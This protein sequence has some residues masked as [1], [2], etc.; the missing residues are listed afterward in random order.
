MSA[1]H[2]G[3][4]RSTPTGLTVSIH[5]LLYETPF[6]PNGVCRTNLHMRSLIIPYDNVR[7]KMLSL[8]V[9]H[10]N[11]KYTDFRLSIIILPAS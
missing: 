8:R 9:A 2:L 6:I 7:V 1:P 4:T 3:E 5:F 10:T 11:E